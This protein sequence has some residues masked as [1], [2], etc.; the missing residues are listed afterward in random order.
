MKTTY[1]HNAYSILHVLDF[2]K[3]YALILKL[4]TNFYSKDKILLLAS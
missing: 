1:H 3:G 4:Q 2:I